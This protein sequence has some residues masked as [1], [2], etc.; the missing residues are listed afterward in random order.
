[1][2]SCIK[3]K[4]IF[5][6]LIKIFNQEVKEKKY[7]KVNKISNQSIKRVRKNRQ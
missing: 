5:K 7:I 4:F 3:K 2:T 1:M 6:C